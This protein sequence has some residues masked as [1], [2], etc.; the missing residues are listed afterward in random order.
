MKNL[1]K[2][3][4][5]AR[6]NA[7][8]FKVLWIILCSLVYFWVAELISLIIYQYAE[9]GFTAKNTHRIYRFLMKVKEEPYFVFEA[10]GI[11]AE[12]LFNGKTQKLAKFIPLIVPLLFLLIVFMGYMRSPHSFN[13]WYKL[14]NHFATAAE[15]LRMRILGGGLMSLGKFEGKSLGLNKIASLFGWGAYELGKTTTVAVPS[16]LESNQASIVAVDSKGELVEYTSGHRAGLGRIFYFNWGLT[17]NPSKN[18]YWPRWNPLSD[19]D[20]PIKS[21]KRDLYLKRL[22]EHLL[23]ENKDQQWMEFSNQ[24]IEGILNFFVCK[25]EQACANDYLLSRLLERGNFNNED[26]DI[27]LSYYAMMPRKIAAQGIENIKQNI[28]DMDNYLPVGSWGGI[29]DVWQGKE[30]C[31][32]MIMDCLTQKYFMTKQNDEDDG[33]RVVVEEFLQESML[34]GYGM[35]AIDAFKEVLGLSRKQR[36]MLMMGVLSPLSVFRKHSIRERTSVSDFSLKYARGMKDNKTGD[37]HVNTT[38]LIANNKDS[39]FMTR[40]MVDMLIERNL[41]KHKS[42]YRNPILFVFDDMEVLPKFQSLQKGLLQG[43]KTNVGFLLLTDGLK[44]LHENYGRDGLEDIVSC[45]TYKLIFAD[46]NIDLSKQFLEMAMFGTKSVQ[47][48]S[49][50][51]GTFAKVKQGI[52]DSYYY[53]KIAEDLIAVRSNKKIDKGQHLLLVEGYYNIPVKV[54]AKCFNRDVRLKT[55]AMKTPSYF[56]DEDL[57]QKRNIQDVDVPELAE[58]LNE[59]GVEEFQEDEIESKLEDDF[60]EEKVVMPSEKDEESWWMNDEAFG[61]NKKNDKNLFEQDK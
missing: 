26:R 3:R 24:V 1:Y 11:W 53:R 45:C 59:I 41:E 8:W 29:P 40:L 61:D 23:P 9:F 14:H 22:A 34:F 31:L 47:I 33:W 58:V 49:V 48:P 37:W 30:L 56:L 36:S 17:D 7:I 50:N 10:Y 46:N 12:S 20:M 27:L 6:K 51:T 38:Y 13:L 2:K 25:I 4:I 54:D 55:L 35:K 60:I 18:E 32:A 5:N 19:K 43:A 21:E 15:V 42:A 52:A 44:K 16:I 57:Q 28:M 39:A